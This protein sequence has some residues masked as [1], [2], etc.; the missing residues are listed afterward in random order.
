[1]PDPRNPFF[2][3]LDQWVQSGLSGPEGYRVTGLVFFLNVFGGPASIIVLLV[4][5]IV[6][7]LMRRWFSVLFTFLAFLVPSIL[8]QLL[9]NF[10]D[11]PRP[12]NPLVM[13]DHGSFPSG[14]VTTTAAFVI[15]IAALMHPTVRKYW[16]IAGIIFILA[17]MWSRVFLNAHWFT[18]TVSGA[19]LGTGTALMLWWLF[20]PLLNRDGERAAV[21]KQN[22]EVHRGTRSG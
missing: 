16:W 7:A 15:L 14:H 3:G 20:A 6:L 22:M 18:D 5:L 17:M 8:A 13:V 4:M 11:R 10:V 12:L 19:I 2:Q 1:M 9:K 21:R